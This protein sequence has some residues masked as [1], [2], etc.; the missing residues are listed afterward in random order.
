[1][2]LQHSILYQFKA[3][4]MSTK[5]KLLPFELPST[6]KFCHYD[7][8]ATMRN[9]I[10]LL[11]SSIFLLPYLLFFLYQHTHCS[12]PR[13]LILVSLFCLAVFF[14]FCSFSVL[15]SHLCLNHFYFYTFVFSTINFALFAGQ[16]SIISYFSSLSSFL[17]VY[18]CL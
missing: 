12:N 8:S 13:H 3:L 18:S 7:N 2:C 15:S 11:F 16:L 4:L 14:P 1:M 5:K 17:S 10:S 9:R 6:L